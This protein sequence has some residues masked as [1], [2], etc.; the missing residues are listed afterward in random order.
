M[1]KNRLLPLLGI[2]AFSGLIIL[3]SSQ[4]EGVVRPQE[5]RLYWVNF[6]PDKPIT[7]I[8]P[9]HLKYVMGANLEIV[10]G[11]GIFEVLDGN[12]DGYPIGEK[13]SFEIRKILEKDDGK[14]Q[15]DQFLQNLDSFD[16]GALINEMAT[17][18]SLT[19][20]EIVYLYKNR[21]SWI[22]ACKD[23]VSDDY[24]F[25]ALSLIADYKKKILLVLSYMIKIEKVGSEY[26]SK[27]G[28]D[29]RPLMF[30][31]V[32]HTLENYPFLDQQYQEKLSMVGGSAKNL[33]NFGADTTLIDQKFTEI[34]SKLHVEIKKKK[35]Q[36][37]K[38]KEYR[39][40]F[41]SM[42][43]NKYRVHL[44]NKNP[45]MITQNEDGSFN[46][47]SKENYDYRIQGIWKKEAKKVKDAIVYMT[48]SVRNL[49][50]K[51]DELCDHGMAN[52]NELIDNKI[53]KNG[54]VYLELEKLATI[55]G[56]TKLS[57]RYMAELAIKRLWYMDKFE[58]Y[59]DNN[60]HLAELMLEVGVEEEL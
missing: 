6:Y 34:I 13:A 55:K 32:I 1:N 31:R 43:S 14:F 7:E 45:L 10:D 19:E 36:E 30:K 54:D 16:R 40:Y 5:D 60:L 9:S 3:N 59:K 29:I 27:Y 11:K 23:L 25:E 38:V 50:E 52:R 57:K 2:G 8:K 24:G 37:E 48:K 22:K 46:T 18:K 47:E 39:A 28:E 42:K 53:F 58:E 49:N 33:V 41:Q 20:T 35:E 26:F 51:I 44:R 4:D 21:F 17:L 15:R 12:M 56:D